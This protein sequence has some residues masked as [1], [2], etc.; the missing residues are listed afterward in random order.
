MSGVSSIN[1]PD[2]RRI[3]TDHAFEGHP[4][5]KDFPLSGCVEVR[6]DDPEKCVVSEPI[7]MI[8]EFRYFDSAS[9][10]LQQAT[11]L[12]LSSVERCLA[13]SDEG[14]ELG[15]ADDGNEGEAVVEA[16]PLALQ[17]WL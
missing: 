8:Q 14:G 4:L 13:R 17:K 3:S 11:S 10:W 9:P 2:L 15:K 6:Y 7:D 12:L 5:R 1:H 16:L